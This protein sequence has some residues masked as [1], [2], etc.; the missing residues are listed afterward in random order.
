MKPL[1]TFTNHDERDAYFREH[2][3]YY[4][5]VCKAG[6]GYERHSY[7]TLAE[8]LRAGQTKQHIGGNGWMVYGVINGQSALV[9]TVKKEAK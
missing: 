1:P 4:T 2:G 8:A 6:L 7:K 9:S 3:E 5:L